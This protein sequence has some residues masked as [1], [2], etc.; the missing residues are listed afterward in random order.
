MSRSPSA[1]TSTTMASTAPSAL[2]EIT[3]SGEVVAV[4]ALPRRHHQPEGI[5]LIAGDVLAL[6]DEGVRGKAHL[7]LYRPRSELR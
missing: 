4:R 3:P 6:A 2:A 5:A 7:T 1:S